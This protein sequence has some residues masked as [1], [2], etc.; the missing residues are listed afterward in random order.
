MSRARKSVGAASAH[1]YEQ[2]I[3]YI[4]KP[5]SLLHFLFL[6]FRPTYL[7]PI[8]NLCILNSV[9]KMSCLLLRLTFTYNC[10]I[11]RALQLDR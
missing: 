5:G 6:L 4:T 7:L 10:T 2:K 3:S 9:H 8:Y 11:L 1:V